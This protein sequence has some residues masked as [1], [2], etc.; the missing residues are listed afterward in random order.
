MDKLGGEIDIPESPKFK[1]DT[2]LVEIVA[3][4]DKLNIGKH[5]IVEVQTMDFHGSYRAATESLANAIQLHPQSF[6][7]QLEQNP[8]W[9]GT[10]IQSPNIANVF[11][12]T[13]Y[14]IL[15]K[16]RLSNNEDCAG[17]ILA[18]PES[19]WQS[20]LPHLGGPELLSDPDGTCRIAVEP[21]AAA[22]RSS[23]GW[24]LVFDAAPESAQTPNPIRITKVIHA[25]PET[26]ADLAFRKA[27]MESMRFLS[28]SDSL[29]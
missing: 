20:W 3:C 21:G 12:R 14:Q 10:G 16:F 18:I 8:N 13:I 15:F 11:K 29:R 24:I 6:P 25:D 7:R 26:L 27:P 17:C 9:A 28:C 4:G 5:G 1:L 2:T 22:R 19:V 23:K